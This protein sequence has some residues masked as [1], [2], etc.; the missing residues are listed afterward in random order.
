MCYGGHELII[1]PSMML[2]N[3]SCSN[4]LVEQCTNHVLTKKIPKRYVI[5]WF[6]PFQAMVKPV[7][8]TLE[9]LELCTPLSC[10]PEVN[11]EIE[12]WPFCKSIVNLS[13]S[14]PILVRSAPG[15]IER[16]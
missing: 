1:K 6:D 8:L 2:R 5:I 15:L 13:I 16:V 4:D 9:S 14:A 7:L 3:S 10:A 12:R 11:R